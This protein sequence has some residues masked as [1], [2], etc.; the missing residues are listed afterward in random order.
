[1]FHGRRRIRVKYPDTQYKVLGGKTNKAVMLCWC[2][3]AQ[4]DKLK[5]IFVAITPLSTNTVEGLDSIN[6]KDR[7]EEIILVLF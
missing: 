2:L 7:K 1:M 5:A 6:Y 3:D 4:N